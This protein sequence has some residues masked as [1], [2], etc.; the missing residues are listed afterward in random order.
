MLA[1]DPDLGLCGEK[2][3]MGVAVP[4]TLSQKLLWS[5]GQ[6]DRGEWTLPS[7]PDGDFP[8]AV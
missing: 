1:K 5:T 4:V 3:P 6:R 2:T 7:G 8:P